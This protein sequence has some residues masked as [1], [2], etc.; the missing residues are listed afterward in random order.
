M[1]AFADEARGTFSR[2]LRCFGVFLLE[3]AD[4]SSKLLKLV[5]GCLLLGTSLSSWLWTRAVVGPRRAE[6]GCFLLD[7]DVLLFS[8]RC[9]L[10]V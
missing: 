2:P 4:L 10:I 8:S 9:P 6:V 3:P 7:F 5:F 1:I